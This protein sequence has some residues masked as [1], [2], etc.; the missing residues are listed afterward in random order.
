MSKSMITGIQQIREGTNQSKGIAEGLT[1]KVKEALKDQ[2]CSRENERMNM[3]G[4]YVG[5]YYFG[6]PNSICP[7]LGGPV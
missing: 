5:L 6:T 4:Y 2:S 7:D 1:S 3:A